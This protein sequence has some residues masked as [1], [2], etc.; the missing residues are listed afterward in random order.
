MDA[1]ASGS[2]AANP[3]AV[4]VNPVQ[5][6]AAATA[7]KSSRASKASAE[8]VGKLCMKPCCKKKQCLAKG[9]ITVSGIV[10]IRERN[11]QLVEGG[12]KTQALREKLN[13]MIQGFR[14]QAFREAQL[15]CGLEDTRAMGPDVKYKF[16]SESTGMARR[17]ARMMP[18]WRCCACI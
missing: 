7:G 17:C 13:R 6:R 14:E 16:Y 10:E 4:S 9:M 12:G 8:L 2:L 15:G 3:C 1:R 11:A 5:K 18:G